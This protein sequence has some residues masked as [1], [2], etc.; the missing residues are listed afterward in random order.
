LR[1]NSDSVIYFLDPLHGD[2]RFAAERESSFAQITLAQ[3]AAIL[4]W[5]RA[6]R[7]WPEHRGCRV[8]VDGAI[9]YWSARASDMAG[10]HGNND[11]WASRPR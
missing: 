11:K 7:R 4:A 9:A 5:L 3:A 8:P 1:E 6:V 10:T 2:P